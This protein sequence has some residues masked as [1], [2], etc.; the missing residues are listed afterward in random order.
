MQLHHTKQLNVISTLMVLVLLCG[1]SQPTQPIER[2][3][4]GKVSLSDGTCPIIHCNTYQTDALPVTGPQLPSQKL[5]EH[6]IDHLWS[7]PIA[8]GVL[9][10]TYQ[11]GSTVFWVSQVDRIMKLRLNEKNQLEKIA[12]LP[13]EPKDFPRFSPQTMQEKIALLDKTPL[14]T[15]HYDLLAGEWEGYQLEGLRAYYAMVNS[16]GILYVG[17]RDSVIAYGDAQQGKADSGIVKLG[18]YGFHKSKLQLGIKMPLVIMIGMNITPDGHLVA[19]TIDGTVIGI[20]PDLSE[21]VYYKLPDEQ[22]WNSIAID[23]HGGIYVVG[24]KKLHKL[25]WTGWG[26]SDKASDGAWVE[27]Y[28]LGELD[29]SL[30][31]ERGSGTTA[32]LMGG[33][34]DKDRFVVIADGADVNNLVLYWRDEIPAAW[35]QLPGVSSRRIAGLLPV[36]FGDDS[37]SNSYSENSAT[38]FDYG[39]VLGNNQVK[40]LE[41]MMLDVQLKMKDPKR[42]PYGLQKFQWNKKLRKLEIA[43]VRADVSSPNSTPVV[44]TQNRQLHAV[45]LKEGKWG[46]ETIDW[47]SGQTRA[48]Y[49]LGASERYNPIMLALQILPNGDPIYPSFGGVMHLRLG[50]ETRV[51]QP[52]VGMSNISQ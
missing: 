15:K 8:G 33:S 37:I 31:A 48:L 52:P 44:S 1:C 7:S 5:N 27:S 18:Q 2:L 17:N 35:Q 9:D 29:E 51:G 12:E 42:T 22:I 39:A 43:W 47:D 49:T 32:A 38:I 34:Q 36:N 50:R 25:I 23:D 10:Y 11:D 4:A 6:Q 3:M 13:L 40:T 30:R 16:E 14:S 19:V 46:L 26:F 24:N 41:K 28:A 21:A 20:K 45:G